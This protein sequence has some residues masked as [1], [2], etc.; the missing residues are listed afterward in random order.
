MQTKLKNK[1]E[2]NSSLYNF[3]TSKPIIVLAYS[4]PS[5]QMAL[6]CR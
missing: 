2:N 4:K 5:L 3:D 6:A 1:K